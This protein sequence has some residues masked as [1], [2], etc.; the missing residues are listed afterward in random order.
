MQLAARQVLERV[1]GLGVAA[2]GAPGAGKGK[3]AAAADS[4]QN[5]MEGWRKGW[6]YLPGVADN[7]PFTHAGAQPEGVEVLLRQ[8]LAQV[9]RPCLW[10]VQG[11]VR[12]QG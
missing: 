6:Q 9:V 4:A 3:V 11:R 10:N 8:V 1:Y 2:R 7:R 5:K 12:D